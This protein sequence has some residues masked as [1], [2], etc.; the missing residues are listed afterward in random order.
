MNKIIIT[1]SVPLNNVNP[2]IAASAKLLKTLFYLPEGN[3]LAE[4]FTVLIVGDAN[5]H[6]QGRCNGEPD[7]CLDTLPDYGSA[8]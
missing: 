4:R 1:E 7:D 2:T 6:N 5:G 8:A 3:S